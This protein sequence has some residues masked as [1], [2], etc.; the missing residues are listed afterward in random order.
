MTQERTKIA[1][2][3][4]D[5]I[6]PEIMK[7]TL[8]ILK[9]SGAS[10]EFEEVQLGKKAFD[11]GHSSGIPPEA[12][13]TIR[14]NKVLLKAP[15][16]TPQGGGYKSLNVTLRKSLGLFA[17]VRPCKA[18]HPFV[19][20]YYPN[21]D[22]VIIRENEEDL[23]A[24][25]E[26]QQTGEMVESLKLVSRP[27]SEDVIRYAFEYAKAHNREL[28]TCMTKDNIM[29]QSDGL[30]HKVFNEVA[31]EYPGIQTEHWI[32]DIGAA[33]VATNPE[34]LDVV[35]TLNLYGDVL[36]DIAAQVAG[37]VGL[38]GSSNVG[39]ECAMFEAIHGSAPD[40]AGKN[41]A[42]PSGL[43]NAAIMML[44]HTGQPGLA[45]LIQNAWL[46]TLE[47]GIH[48][49]DI[50]NSGRSNRKVTTKEFTAAIKE[51]LGNEPVHLHPVR[52]KDTGSCI[53]ISHPQSKPGEK[54]L[55][56]VDVY[57][58]WTGKNRDPQELAN[59]LKNLDTGFI[60]RWIANRG[61]EVYPEQ[62][63]ETY[64]SDHWQCRFMG[65]APPI[66]ITQ[67]VDLLDDITKTGLEFIKTELLY[68]IDGKKAYSL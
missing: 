25:I 31:Q 8:D 14:K 4:G 59:M 43:L 24:G 12:W 66:Q 16:T 68:T 28:I 41:V 33:H 18:Y 39:R 37:S 21:M 64:P 57:L 48:T 7:A 58:D 2:A 1:V 13:E 44:D 55:T 67:V 45:E 56:G 40:I 50:Y 3:H 15:I 61:V 60:L 53:S 63:P 34:D 46:K 22:L 17:N 32:I 49:A 5:G 62:N 42:N 26:Y 30:F 38:G 65:M 52:Y 51:R 35:V 36:S 6:G 54:Q 29:K 9:A 11:Q 19:H 23:Y 27:G 20:A 10:F 47:E